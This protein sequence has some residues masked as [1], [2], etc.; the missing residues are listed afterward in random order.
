MS[1]FG[2]EFKRLLY[3]ILY[4]Y[5]CS[6]PCL[7]PNY[8]HTTDPIQ[9]WS[10][11]SLGSDCG[12]VVN[13]CLWP[14]PLNRLTL[15]SVNNTGAQQQKAGTLEPPDLTKNVGSYLSPDLP[16]LTSISTI[17]ELFLTKINIIISLQYTTEWNSKLN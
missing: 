1:L 4:K 2:C 12:E 13:D 8:T 9:V 17:T 7:F 16:A 15:S 10:P 11:D 3:Q 6:P 14:V 5:K